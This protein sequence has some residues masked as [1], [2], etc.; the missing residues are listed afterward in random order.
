MLGQD[1]TLIQTFVEEMAQ[2]GET[3]TKEIISP[4]KRKV[5]P[6]GNHLFPRDL[7][8]QDTTRAVAITVLVVATKRTKTSYVSKTQTIYINVTGKNDLY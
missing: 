5:S 1:K 6:F 7:A 4:G 3:R 2:H 8:P